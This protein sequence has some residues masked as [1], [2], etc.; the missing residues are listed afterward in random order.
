M[1][2]TS[3][4]SLYR[5]LRRGREILV[6]LR[7]YGL[8]D[9]LSRS[10]R[11]P[12]QNWIKDRSGV[13]LTQYTRAERIR[14]AITELGPT[15]IKVGQV[16]ASR[17]DLVG[18]ELAE[19]LKG[20]R[21]D[22]RPD[23]EAQV[24]ATLTSELG[25][26]YESRFRSIEYEPLATA[27]I[28]QVH[29]AVLP[30]GRRVVLKIQRSGID[31]M[32]K[33]DLEVLE[34]LAQLASRVDAL[35]V[36]GPQQMVRQLMPMVKNE[37]D[38]NRERGSLKQFA[39]MLASDRDEVV[40]PDV[41]D[42][43]CTRRVLVMNEM[44]GVPLAKVF[45]H[46]NVAEDDVPLPSGDSS[47]SSDRPPRMLP[48][49]FGQRLARVY[50]KMVFEDGFFHADP[51]PG[52]LYYLEDGR[53]GILDFGMTGRIDESLRESIEEMLLAIHSGDRRR[54]TRLIRQVGNPRVDLDQA[55]L[56]IDVAD[57]VDTFGRQSL[58]RF[59]LA[60]ALNQLTEIL[61]QHGISLPNQSALLLK[62]LISLEG[63]LRELGVGFDSLDIVQSYLRRVMY[64]RLMPGRRLRQARR[65]YLENEAFMEEAPE[66]V[67]SLLN[68]AQLG[69][70]Q[71]RLEPKRFAPVV[72]RLV[73]GLMASAVF[74]GSALLLAYEV[75]PVLFPDE[76]VMG[77]Q[78][79][80]TLGL[81]G[82]VL[83]IGVMGFLCLAIFRGDGD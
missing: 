51:H 13:P 16:L 68:Q 1:K 30:D 26:D 19:E 21:S 20:L 24:R 47:P 28:G 82:F 54:L 42:S 75:S 2:L 12:L 46:T 69:Q 4:P 55:A 83:S 45:S 66:R 3:I 37:L 80:S 77:I 58:D 64:R 62:M 14:K 81:I 52:N 44:I 78:R 22:V 61:H 29:R 10:Q 63:T 73:I 48:P 15:F 6:V 76:P 50:L 32:M 57:F 36:W 60:G 65:I 53:L 17:P 38:F 11:M 72:N 27:S 70:L 41:I 25:E 40:V 23:S 9:W 49:D 18:I 33:Q 74:L 7:R 35:A 8:A 34:G 39:E 79:L 71:F 43:L 67:L 59:D 5:N 31:R 56:E